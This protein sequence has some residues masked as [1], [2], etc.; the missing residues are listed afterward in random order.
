[1]RLLR[2]CAL[3][4]TILLL[5]A[6]VYLA[7]KTGEIRI[8]TA[9][10]YYKSICD[11]L[12]NHPE[13]E[14]F[15]HMNENE[16]PK[17]GALKLFD[18]AGGSVLREL[19]GG[20]LN[21]YKTMGIPYQERWDSSPVADSTVSIKPNHEHSIFVHDDASRGFVVPVKGYRPEKTAS[22]VDHVPALKGAREI[23]CMESSVFNLVESMDPLDAELFYY[24][25][26][27][28]PYPYVPRKHN[29]NIIL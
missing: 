2:G 19:N 8:L 1:M 17:S 9:P 7:R 10:D 29:W 24:P 23:H 14:A 16:L 11:L 12:V 27:K 6:A 4:D 3:G 15:T 5:G 18:S 13:V 21:W 20:P 22:I 26:V 28:S 25:K